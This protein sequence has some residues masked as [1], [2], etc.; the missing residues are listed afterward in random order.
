VTVN[1]HDPLRDEG[2]E[3]ARRLAHANVPV[4]LQLYAGTFHGS[5]SIAADAEV[6]QRQECDLRAAIARAFTRATS[7]NHGKD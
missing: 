1:Q 5:A 3:Y 4:D 2:I 7:D 6:S